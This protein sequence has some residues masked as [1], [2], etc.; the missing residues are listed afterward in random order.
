MSYYSRADPPSARFQVV[1]TPGDGY[2][3]CWSLD[4]AEIADFHV[5]LDGAV[6]LVGPDLTELA[7]T[8]GVPCYVSLT[9]YSLRHG[10]S[11][12]TALT[13]NAIKI[14]QEGSRK[15]AEMLSLRLSSSEGSNFFHL[16]SLESGI[17]QNLFHTPEFNTSS[18]ALL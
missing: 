9:G 2:K 12:D 3:L 6:D 11:D 18:H 14:L 10:L 7:C 15:R 17:L 1:G 8:L 16:L 13:S 4:S 5:Q